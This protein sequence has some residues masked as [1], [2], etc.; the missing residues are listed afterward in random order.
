MTESSSQ[1]RIEDIKKFY[2][3]LACIE[4]HVK[5]CRT[6]AECNGGM[7]WPKRGV[8]FFFEPG[9]QR[10]CSGEGA[11]VVRVGTHAITNKSNTTLWIRL[12]QHRGNASGGG[13]HRC[14]VFRKLI[15]DALAKSGDCQLPES[16]NIKKIEAA[17][18]K[19]ELE[20]EK[21]VSSYIGKMPFLWL[22][23][24][25]E[26]SPNSMRA[27]IERNAI[28][29]LSNAEETDVID[30]ASESWLGNNSEW[31]LVQAS[32]LWNRD[33]VDNDYNPQFLCDM[34]ELLQNWK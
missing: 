10:C 27:C 28:A 29:L 12:R 22:C 11:R 33:Y 13:D 4:D 26:P 15:G 5:G 21:R 23:V 3:I 20:L 8:Y 7:N 31:P 32:G 1:S 6:L 17:E 19:M 16:W 9:E 18:R 14:S 30:E 24:P 34:N 25:D 2:D